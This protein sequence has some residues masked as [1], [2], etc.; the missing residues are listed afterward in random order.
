MILDPVSF[1]LRTKLSTPLFAFQELHPSRSPSVDVMTPAVQFGSVPWSIRSFGGIWRTIQQRSSSSLF[2]WRPLWAVLARDGTSTPWRCLFSISSADH[3]VTHPPRCPKGWFL[4]GCRGAWHARAMRVFR[5]LTF[6]SR[7]PVGP[8]KK[9]IFLLELTWSAYGL[10][11]VF[12]Y[13]IKLKW[14]VRNSLEYWGLS[15]I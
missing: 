8:T 9:L 12:L 13:R 4:S 7:N 1:C 11:R 14:S 6:V 3:G 2:F 5:L 15:L 10:T